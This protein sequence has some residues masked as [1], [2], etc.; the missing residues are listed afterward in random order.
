MPITESQTRVLDARATAADELVSQ[1]RAMKVKLPTGYSHLTYREYAYLCVDAA[2]YAT[3]DI[4]LEEARLVI[5]RSYEGVDG[6]SLESTLTVSASS[7]HP[8]KG[9]TDELAA[10][11]EYTDGFMGASAEFLQK[12]QL[13]AYWSYISTHSDSSESELDRI[14][15]LEQLEDMRDR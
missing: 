8:E 7:F 1:Y 13:L 6:A 10:G 12:D 5:S 9:V 2:L 11:V 3:V 14:S 4:I 15:G